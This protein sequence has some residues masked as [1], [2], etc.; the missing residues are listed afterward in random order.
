MIT[1]YFFCHLRN[2]EI[3]YVLVSSICIDCHIPFYHYQQT[4]LGTEINVGDAG[5]GKETRFFANW[6]TELS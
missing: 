6:P 3:Y 2:R 4:L 5:C 1:N